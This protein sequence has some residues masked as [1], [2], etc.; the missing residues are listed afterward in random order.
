MNT[1]ETDG[2]ALG[3]QLSNALVSV[4][5]KIPQIFFPRNA[6]HV[7]ILPVASVTTHVTGRELPLCTVITARDVTVGISQCIVC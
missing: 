4:L 5:S 7:I 3:S 6:M 1:R 2:I